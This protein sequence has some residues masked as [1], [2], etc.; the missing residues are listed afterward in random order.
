VLAVLGVAGLAACGPSSSAPGATGATTGSPTPTGSSAPG[1]SP[2]STAPSPGTTLSSANDN[3]ETAVISN[4]EGDGFTVLYDPSSLLDSS[5]DDYALKIYGAAGN[6]LPSLPAGQF[7]GGCGAADVVTAAGRLIITLLITATPAQ[8][9]VQPSNK[10]TM[11]AWNAVTG[12]SVWTDTLV[13]S[14]TQQIPCPLSD[15]EL[16]GDLWNFVPTL[17]GHWGVFVLPT[18]DTNGDT[19]SDAIDLTTGKLYPNRDL[20][21]VLG[22]DVVIGSGSGVVNGPAT[23]TVTAPGTWAPLGSTT[24]GSGTGV[25]GGTGLPLQGQASTQ[26]GPINYAPT[27]YT[28]AFTSFDSD[29]SPGPGTGI[30]AVA[31]PD[32]DFLIATYSDSSGNL[33]YGGYSLPSLH[34]VW[35]AQDPDFGNNDQITGVSDTALLITR[36]GD[37]GD[38]YL[39]SLDPATGQQ[40]WKIDI[41]AGA[42]VCD[43]TSTQVLG[44]ANSQLATLSAATGRQLSYEPDP[45]RDSSG[46]DSC[47]TVVESGLGGIGFNNDQ[48]T[49]LLMP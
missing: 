32:G 4:R 42:S 26:N 14:T 15:H 40:Q 37:D 45:Y 30:G 18:T 35:S 28:G 48:V 13:E 7:S 1:R 8:G 19:L 41:G 20:E 43:L 23:L 49:Q 47:P 16:A 27:G 24:A 21:G 29:E 6:R 9:I 10:L 11:T 39:L 36:V 34:Q 38:T 46:G 22:N 5:T 3:G 33:S 17:D 25:D 31:T 2:A 44:L 12:A